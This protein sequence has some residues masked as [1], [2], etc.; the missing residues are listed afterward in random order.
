MPVINLDNLRTVSIVI[1]NNLI[2]MGFL[3]DNLNVQEDLSI[4]Q[5][6]VDVFLDELDHAKSDVE[7]AMEQF[8]ESLTKQE[9]QAMSVSL[10]KGMAAIQKTIEEVND[11]EEKES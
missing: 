8:A 1:H 9:A 11:A 4:R 5:M 3:P 10:N 7:R 6:I 2:K